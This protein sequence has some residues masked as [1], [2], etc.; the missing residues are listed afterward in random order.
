MLTDGTAAQSINP[1]ALNLLNA[2]LT[3]GKWLIPTP[4]A[5][6]RVTGTV[7]STYNEVQFNTNLDYQ[8][9]HRDSLSAKFFFANAPQLTPLVGAALGGANLPGFGMQIGNDNRVLS[10]SYIH[11]FGPNTWIRR[12][13]C[14]VPSKMA[15]NPAFSPKCLHQSFDFP[16][17]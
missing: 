16:K 12:E 3:D 13:C 11:L 15:E 8:T 5:D 9:G 4:Q 7:P 1:V 10:V 2:K 6:G 14:S 17:S